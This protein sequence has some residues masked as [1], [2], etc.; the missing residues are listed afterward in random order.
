MLLRGPFYVLAK[1]LY[2][3][4]GAFSS[5]RFPKAELKLYEG[6]DDVDKVTEIYAKVIKSAN[7]SRIELRL[8]R[9]THGPP[10]K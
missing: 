2:E 8:R 1:G 7:I 4:P 6:A 9:T 3:L 10:T 5:I